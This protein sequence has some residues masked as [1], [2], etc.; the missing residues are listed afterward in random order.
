MFCRAGQWSTRFYFYPAISVV[1]I[2]PST[3]RAQHANVVTV[4][5]SNFVR[6]RELECFFGDVSN[7]ATFVSVTRVL[8]ESPELTTGVYE[9]KLS[10]NRQ[11]MVANSQFF[12]V[13]PTV[14][15]TMADSSVNL[16]AMHHILQSR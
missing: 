6:S 7:H 8:C 3:G 10:Y 9:L 1:E 16:W 15:L 14:T 12:E 4:D 11:D 5:G 13:L 2:Y